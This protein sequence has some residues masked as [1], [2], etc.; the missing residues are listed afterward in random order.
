M[1]IVSHAEI[2]IDVLVK[3]APRVATLHQPLPYLSDAGREDSCGGGRSATL[4][5]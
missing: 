4:L 2:L 1:R 5:H 3:K